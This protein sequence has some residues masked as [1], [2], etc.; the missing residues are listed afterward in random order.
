MEEEWGKCSVDDPVI[1]ANNLAKI[2]IMGKVEVHALVDVSLQI[3]RGEVVSIM[4]PS[5]QGNPRS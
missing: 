5:A 2:Y 4:G 1:V 3:N